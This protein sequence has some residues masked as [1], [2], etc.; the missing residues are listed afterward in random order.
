MDLQS[1]TTTVVPAKLRVPPR[2]GLARRRLT[3][4]LQ[5]AVGTGFGTVVGPAGSGKTTVLAQF[6]TSIEAPSAWYRADES[7]GEI[8]PLLAH[9][10][11]ALCTS[12][13]GLAGGWRSLE[14]MVADLERWSGRQA[15][16]V[17]DD[18]H[19]LEGTPA[20][21]F[22]ARLVDYAPAS[23]VVLVAARHQP[24]FNLSRRRID[25]RLTEVAAHDLRF[26]SWEVEQLFKDVYRAPLSPEEVAEVASRT[27]GWAAVLQLF[28]LATTGKT[29]ARRRQTLGALSTRSRLVRE[30]LTQNVLEHLPPDLRRF[31]L[32]TCV[33]PRLSGPLC[34]A[35]LERSGSELLLEQAES[36]QLFLASLEDGSFRCHEILRSYLESVLVAEIGEPETS[37]RYRRAGRMLEDAAAYTDAIRAYSRAGDDR[38]I[39]R[40]LRDRGEAV[41]AEPGAWI[42]TLP[43]GIVASDPWLLLARSRRH[44]AC[45]R[46]AEAVEGYRSAEGAFGPVGGAVEAHHERL[47]LGGWLQPV[48]PPADDW[49]GLLRE[50]TRRDPLG[51][52]T[53]AR[54]LDGDHATLAAGVAAL[55]AGHVREAERLLAEAEDDPES[56]RLR[57]VASFARAVAQALAGQRPVERLHA[58]YEAFEE[59]GQPWL[60]QLAQV[61]LEAIEPETQRPVGPEPDDGGW[62]RALGAIL[63][64]G[65]GAGPGD[66]EGLG[67][68]AAVFR[69][70]GARVLEA[71]AIALE[72]VALA[73]EG[74]PRAGAAATTAERLARTT[75]T[76][77]AAVV[78]YRALALTDGAQGAKHEALAAAIARECGL[79]AAPAGG[80]GARPAGPPSMVVRCFGAFTMEVQGE[81]LDLHGVKPRAR[82]LLRLLVIHQGRLLHWEA[83]VEALWPET[84]PAAGKRSLQVAVSA[85]RQL[86]EPGSSPDSAV[87]AR[88]GDAY[89]LT[90]PDDADLDIARFEALAHRPGDQAAM[91]E[92]LDLYRGDLL[93]EEGPAEWVVKARDHYRA[94]AADVAERLAGLQLAEG[95][96]AAVV[97]T[98]QR[99]LE[100]DRYRDRLWRLLVASHR[101]SGDQAAAGRSTRDYESVLLELGVV[102]PPVA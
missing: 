57:A 34:D 88:V 13:S 45:G 86:I 10:E 84:S 94:T 63:R 32:D 50:A 91:T 49:L 48:S 7:D 70:G 75:G 21:G 29:A 89:A 5:E 54:L 65:V 42:E 72:A 30:Y 52:S 101:E 31:L 99:G 18:F 40:L 16:L 90:L 66:S 26:R 14:E 64:A 95:A 96:F 59:L 80:G 8:E 62:G 61:V 60:A 17:V 28:H 74:D 27:E 98:C 9:L 33:L 56:P 6:L 1:E 73:G 36:R 11:R 68:A 2:S 3:D 38:A 81:L 100:I 20:E 92:A 67:S 55:L 77:G 4:K 97:R 43:S 51:A 41:G 44:L 85:I 46:V 53:R 24:R 22:V 93:E 58:A 37:A 15:V 83:L 25:G 79:R 71:W 87:L 19:T 69:A 35:L 82:S 47:A 12:L 39:G 102:A 78:A 76:R 23:L